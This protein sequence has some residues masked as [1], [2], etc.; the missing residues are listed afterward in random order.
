MSGQSFYNRRTPLILASFFLCGAALAAYGDPRF[1]R[2]L[3]ALTVSSFPSGKAFFIYQFRF[4]GL[5]F[6]LGSSVIGFLVIPAAFLLRGLLF[7]QS[8]SLLLT[9]GF[10]AGRILMVLALPSLLSLSGLF[11]LGG[12]AFDSSRSVYSAAFDSTSF[13]RPMAFAHT[14]G[15]VALCVLSGCVYYFACLYY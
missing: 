10:T 2:W 9:D 11:L 13:W 1:L 3:S 8:V 14:S 15:A 4:L 12:Q 6:F 5:L 7:T